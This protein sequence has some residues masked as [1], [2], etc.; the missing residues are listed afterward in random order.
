VTIPNTRG[1]NTRNK[2]A[3]RAL[4]FGLISIPFNPLFLFSLLSIVS[5]ARGLTRSSEVRA[6]GDE[7]TGR[8]M[9]WVGIVLGILGFA[10]AI[11]VGVRLLP[12]LDGILG[13]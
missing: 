3:E 8:T 5:G 12:R 2:R 13:W 11:V 1:R 4:I 7:T 6:A 9:A 10:I